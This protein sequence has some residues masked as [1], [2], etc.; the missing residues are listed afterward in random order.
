MSIGYYGYAKLANIFLLTNTGGLNREVNPILSEAVWGAGWYTGAQHTNYAD[1]QMNYAG[2]LTFELQGIPSVWNVVTDWLINNRVF[3]KNLIVSPNGLV[4]QSY[5]ADPNDPTT[6]AW[7]NTSGFTIDPAASIK[8]NCNVIA[9]KRSETYASVTAQSPY[10]AMSGKGGS[11]TGGTGTPGPPVFPGQQFGVPTSPLNPIPTNRNP[12]PGWAA[13][14]Q[15]VWP[16]SPPVFTPTNPT[17]MF[18][19]SA[20]WTFNNNTQVVRGCTGQ[21]NPAAVM[22]GVMAVEGTMRLFRDGVIQDPYGS[23][24]IPPSQTQ[25]FTASGASIQM[26]FG[27]L[28]PIPTIQFLHVLLTSEE[29]AIAGQNEIVPRTFGFAGLGDGTQPPMLMPNM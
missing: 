20:D 7:M 16:G 8:L 11:F 23:T 12:F 14:T 28:A 18:M 13:Q 2:A 29:F 5:A 4:V 9:L 17:G 1:S 24:N 27:N 19:M 21:P 3:P 15:I 25:P 26:T 10:R 6:G 22:Q